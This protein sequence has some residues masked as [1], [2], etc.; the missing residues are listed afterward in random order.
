VR[1][2]FKPA[3]WNAF[4]I[5]CQGPRVQIWLNGTQTVDY[6][7]PDAKIAR[8]GVIAVQIHGGPAA[9]ASYRNLRIKDLSDVR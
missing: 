5:R 1:Q 9:E 8:R 2:I 3:D 4:I 7:E 6:T